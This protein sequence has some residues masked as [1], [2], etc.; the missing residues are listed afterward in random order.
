[1][2]QYR[3]QLSL[4]LWLIETYFDYKKIHTKYSFQ[5]C[6]Y[7]FMLQSA[8]IKIFILKYEKKFNYY[9]LITKILI[10]KRG[11]F[12]LFSLYFIYFEIYFYIIE[13]LNKNIL[14][15]IELI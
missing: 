10:F 9:L 6:T 4:N 7:L 8:E 14:L 11:L 2:I 12:S 3:W 15:H 1:M 5:I 13:N